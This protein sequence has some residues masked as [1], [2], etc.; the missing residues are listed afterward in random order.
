M[1]TRPMATITTPKTRTRVSWLRRNIDPTKVAPM[2]RAVNTE[3]KP[4]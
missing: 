1:V 2:P 3:V 4:A